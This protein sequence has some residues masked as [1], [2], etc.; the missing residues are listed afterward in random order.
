MYSKESQHMEFV[1]SFAEGVL[2]KRSRRRAEGP[3]RYNSERAGRNAGMSCVVIGHSGAYLLWAV[4][5]YLSALK[6][7]M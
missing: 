2:V 7:L 6:Q 4:H 1:G 5:S 3:P